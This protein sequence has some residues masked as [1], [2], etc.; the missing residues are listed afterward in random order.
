MDSITSFVHILMESQ[1]FFFYEIG[2][3]YYIN[4]AVVELDV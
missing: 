3:L 2:S 1:H 4:L